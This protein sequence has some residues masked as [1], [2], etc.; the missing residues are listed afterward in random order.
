MTIT[1]QAVSA[2]GAGGLRVSR[3]WAGNVTPA[4]IPVV[5]DEVRRHYITCLMHTCWL[6]MTVPKAAGLG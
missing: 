2:L 4:F 1:S 6:P 5:D 3:R